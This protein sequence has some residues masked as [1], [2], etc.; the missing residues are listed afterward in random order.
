MGAP[1]T[2][3]S[4]V[5]RT[6][7][8]IYGIFSYVVGVAGLAAIVAVLAHVM[9]VGFLGPE[10]TG[11]PIL[12][13]LVLVALWGAIH[14]V[15]ARDW[16]KA[17][18]SRLIP[19]PAER[20]TYVLVAGITSVLLVGYWQTIPGTIWAVTDTTAAALIWAV[21]A[22]GWVYLLAATFAIIPIGAFIR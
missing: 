13:N 21:F 16:F 2:G 5:S 10:Q 4:L 7:V 8:L 17:L 1:N 18:I 3:G 11:F 15:M 14:S 22:F 12:S 9:P 19:E 20:P 6:L